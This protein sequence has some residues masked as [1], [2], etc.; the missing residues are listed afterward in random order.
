MVDEKLVAKLNIST[1]LTL[2][3]VAMYM[4]FLQQD[5]KWGMSVII[6][7]FFLNLAAIYITLTIDHEK[8][9]IMNLV[10][11]MG[12]FVA[13]IMVFNLTLSTM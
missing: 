1:A 13:Q 5:V 12:L 6:I 10:W 8:M 7:S 9:E 11:K 4:I 2:F 3:A